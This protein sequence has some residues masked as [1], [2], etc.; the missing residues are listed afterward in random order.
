MM[1]T[2]NGNKRLARIL[3][4]DDN[5][6]IAQTLSA[7]LQEKGYEVAAAFSGEAAV[8]KAD[9]FLPDLLLSDV[10]M[11]RM[12]GIEAA[13]RITAK[14]PDCRVLFLSGHIS[15]AEVMSAA[16]E[17]LV[18]SFASKPI[19]PLD[20]LSAIAYMLPAANAFKDRGAMA[21]EDEAIE[22]YAPA[23]MR[24]L[25]EFILRH[26]EIGLAAATQ[27]NAGSLQFDCR[28]HGTAGLEMRLP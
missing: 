11:G 24:A 14:L 23:R 15:M 2:W 13:T 17:G 3:V 19:H 28:V 25:A 10:N 5:K 4:V 6:T 9:G 12:N 16:P 21:I 26:A 1:R 18:Y 8:A 20:L 7:I 22:R 27:T